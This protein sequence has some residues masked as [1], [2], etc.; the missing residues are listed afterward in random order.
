[1]S[2]G[3]YMVDEPGFGESLIPIWGSGKAAIADFERGKWGWGLFNTAMAV[4]DVFLVK[5]LI[6]SVIKLGTRAVVSASA[7]AARTAAKE[8]VEQGVKDSMEVVAR[9]GGEQVLSRGAGEGKG[10]LKARGT[11]TYGN[12][13]PGRSLGTTDKFGNVTIRSDLAG[14]ELLETVRHESVHSFF[15]PSAGVIGNIRANIGTAAYWQS[16]F[17]RFL[18]EA[19][20]ETWAT[21]SLRRGLAL[22]FY[23]GYRIA[24]KRVLLE[25]G[26]Y[27]TLVGGS[28][29]YGVYQWARKDR[30]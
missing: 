1:M 15:S 17:V 27:I 30:R 13:G 4:S 10:A 12:T 24:L 5:A 11:F 25:G 2:G 7:K 22:P 21:G 26:A 29:T 3:G 6:T 19:I 23:P 8:V 18:E 14:Q 9:D 20:A 16:H 28:M